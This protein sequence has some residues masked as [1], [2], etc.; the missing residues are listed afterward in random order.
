VGPFGIASGPDG[1]IWF[2]ESSVNRI[3]RMTTSGELAEFS[4][5]RGGSGPSAIAAGRDGNLWF[6]E[7]NANQVAR[8]TPEGVVTEFAVP[9]PA[10]SPYGIVEGP[11]G[12]PGSRKTPPTR[13]RDSGSARLPVLVRAPS[14]SMARE[15]VPCH[16]TSYF[17]AGAFPPSAGR[18]GS[19]ASSSVAAE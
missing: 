1:N 6:T 7:T 19:N 15:R 11:D 9:A 17:F 13:L 4:I 3:G 18:A 14:L 2:T 5:P 10:S 8:V 12:N 16:S